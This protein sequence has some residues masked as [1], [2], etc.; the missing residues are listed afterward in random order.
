MQARVVAQLN[1][2]QPGFNTEQR[3]EKIISVLLELSLRLFETFE[4][5]V[6]CFLLGYLL[7]RTTFEAA[8]VLLSSELPFCKHRMSSLD[9][10]SG[11]EI[12]YYHT[13]LECQ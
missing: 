7:W 2:G 11:C 8:E 1:I 12:R 3:P 9:E 5:E 10:A 13:F 6:E 4:F